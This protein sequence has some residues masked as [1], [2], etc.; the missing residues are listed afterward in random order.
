MAIT[1]SDGTITVTLHPDLFWSD[2][3]NW[4]PVE[5]TAQRSIT[6]AVIVSVASRIAGRSITLEPIDDSSAWMSRSTIDQLRAWAA[7]AGKELVLT[8]AGVAYDVIFRHQEPPAVDAEPV[9]YY[10]D[11]DPSDLFRAT[12]RFMEI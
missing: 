12:L 10:S 5:Q 9:V 6:G 1:L 7:V 4:H 8:I 11:A 3:N 2:Q